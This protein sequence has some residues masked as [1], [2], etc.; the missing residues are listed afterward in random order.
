MNDARMEFL[1]GERPEDVLLYFNEEDVD[2]LD[3]LAEIGES[4]DTGA[5]LV[6]DGSEGRGAFQRAT[7]VDPMSLP[8]MAERVEDSIDRGCTDGEC[9][10]DAD[11]PHR[12]KFLF[13]FA[14]EQNEEVGDIY[15]E[16]QN[17]EVGDIYA[18]GDVIHA[19]AV[20]V[21]GTVYS[22]RWVAGED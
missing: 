1:A 22:E 4:V 8:N 3:R 12:V 15:A 21:C 13:A 20:C 7:G 17:E 5:V 11:E 9:P 16:E 6:L 2:G 18:E 19:Y 14:E 10:S